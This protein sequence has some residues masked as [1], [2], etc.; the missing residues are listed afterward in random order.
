MVLP[1]CVRTEAS[2]A[3]S[4]AA[5]T[6]EGWRPIEMLETWRSPIRKWPHYLKPAR[7]ATPADANWIAELAAE[8]FT[9]DRLHA[10]ELVSKAEADAS[11]AHWIPAAFSDP[12]REIHIPRDGR[13]AFLILRGGDTIDLIAVRASARRRGIASILI[14]QAVAGRRLALTAGTQSTNKPAQALYSSLG[15]AVVRQQTSW[16]KP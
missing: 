7:L 10:D 1:L 14:R 2:D 12:G 5:L 15:M 8:S 6:A 3:R 16:H 11:K 4:A 9:H 13:F